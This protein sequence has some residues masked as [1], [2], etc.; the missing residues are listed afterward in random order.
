VIIY[1]IVN[2]QE[3]AGIYFQLGRKPLRKSAWFYLASQWEPVES[4]GN[5]A[6]FLRDC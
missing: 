2:V 1:N 5:P 6:P 3:F 4:Q